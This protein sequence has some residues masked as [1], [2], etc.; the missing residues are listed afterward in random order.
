MSVWMRK[1]G[2]TP[3]VRRS[4]RELFSGR[5]AYLVDQLSLLDL[6]LEQLLDR[7]LHDLAPL[8]HTARERC[9]RL[10][11]LRL[12]LGCDGLVLLGHAFDLAPDDVERVLEAPR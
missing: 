1:V 3:D 7:V 5:I 11:Q 12:H 10:F 4:P 2:H 6:D 8:L 9:Q